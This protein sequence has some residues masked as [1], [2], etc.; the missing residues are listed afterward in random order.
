V[1]VR[2]RSILN[3]RDGELY[4]VEAV[5]ALAADC[6][7][8]SI[9]EETPVT[10]LEEPPI[11]A[12]EV[13]LATNA[14]T[15]QLLAGIPIAPVRAQMLATAP[16]AGRAAQ[17]P[18]YS[19][20]GYRYWRQ[21]P[22]GEVLVGGWR[23]VALSEEVGY[24]LGTTETVQHHL[25]RHLAQIRSSAGSARDFRSAPGTPGT[26]WPSPSSAPVPLPTISEAD[27]RHQ[28][29][30]TRRAFGSKVGVKT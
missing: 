9:F 5:A 4:P 26:G 27:R 13:V 21:L 6:P 17:Q 7:P 29:G 15:G 11:A 1:E 8:G 18:T 2:A 22:S 10:R 28:A 25:D 3:P 16:F 30:S 24:E 12:E 23:N 20:H 14:F 19:D